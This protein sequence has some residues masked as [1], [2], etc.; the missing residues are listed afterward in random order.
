LTPLTHR[1]VE[2][3]PPP[4]SRTDPFGRAR[5]FELLLTVLD[6][7]TADRPVVL[8]VEELHGA[9]APGGTGHRLDLA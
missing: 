8:V 9:A 3:A 2:P 1:R 4:R 7:V 6:R 5:V